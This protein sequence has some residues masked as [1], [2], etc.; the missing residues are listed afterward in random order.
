MSISTMV[1]NRFKI[2]FFLYR[3]VKIKRYPKGV[4]AQARAGNNS[5]SV[6]FVFTLKPNKFMGGGSQWEVPLRDRKV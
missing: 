5:L 2:Y 1:T 6:Q 4:L 3:K